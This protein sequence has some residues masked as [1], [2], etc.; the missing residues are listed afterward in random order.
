VKKFIRI[1]I[2]LTKNYFQIHALETEGHDVL[3]MP[4]SYT[5]PYVKR[6]KNDAVDA[7]AIWEAMSRPGMRF[8]PIKNAEQQATLM[9]HK[10]REL[11]IKQQ[12]MCVNAL[13]G[14]LSEFGIIVAKGIVRVDSDGH[15]ASPNLVSKNT[16]RPLK[17]SIKSRLAAS[18][19]KVG[20]RRLRTGRPF[21]R[22]PS[23]DFPRQTYSNRTEI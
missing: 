3:L 9:L 2:D 19:S 14:H 17:A 1:G 7:E 15:P 21:S 8:V 5:K 16:K 10:T 22:F 18:G 4:P 13:R 11:L 20:L 23:P 6:G 12:S